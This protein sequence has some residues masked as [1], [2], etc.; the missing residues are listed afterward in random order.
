[1]RARPEKGFTLVELCIVLVLLSILLR[2]GL[3]AVQSM[4]TRARAAQAIGDLN[5]IREAAVAYHAAN[6]TWPAEAGV[7][8]IPPGLAPYLPKGY[9]FTRNQYEL[10]WQNWALPTGLPSNPQRLVLLGVSVVTTDAE[11]GQAVLKLIAGSSPTRTGAN[12][13]TM[14][15]VASTDPL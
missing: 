4:V 11:L 9:S 3:P 7:A 13:Y 5:V 8:T 2:L 6:G 12:Q 14:V 1:M 10:D 15:L